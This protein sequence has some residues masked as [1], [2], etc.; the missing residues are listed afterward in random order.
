MGLFKKLFGKKEEKDKKVT[1]SDQKGIP[2]NEDLIKT[3][4]ND[5]QRLLSEF[6]NISNSAKKYKT[7]LLPQLLKT[8][9]L[10]L[11]I[12]N[13]SEKVQLY[14]YLENYYKNDVEKLEI[15]KDLDKAAE[16][17]FKN[18]FSFLKRFEGVKFDKEICK[19][20]LS[21]WETLGSILQSRINI[22]ESELYPL[23]K[24]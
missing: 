1:L 17:I 3:L 12:H 21:E 14:T 24:K 8:F 18:V 16:E 9:K 2:Y 19:Q 13:Y 23:Y 4:L 10:N 15:I 7:K 6:I 20:F 22:E 5:H 11:E